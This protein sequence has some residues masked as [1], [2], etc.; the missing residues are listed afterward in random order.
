MDDPDD[1]IPGMPVGMN[2]GN[3][4]LSSNQLGMAFGSNAGGVDS[5]CI[6]DPAKRLLNPTGAQSASQQQ[7][8]N[9]RLAKINLDQISLDASQLPAGTDPSSFLKHMNATLVPEEPKPFKCPVVGCE[10]AYKNQ[11]G[12]K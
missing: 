8:L 10:K 11:N 4:N 9:Q 5:N 3:M 6:D 12:L 1:D 2:L 7:A